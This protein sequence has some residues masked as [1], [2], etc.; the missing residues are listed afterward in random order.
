[1]TPLYELL[2]Q[3][4]ESNNPVTKSSLR[5]C[6]RERVWQSTNDEISVEQFMSLIINLY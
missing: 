2:K 1:M 3:Y 6:I 5:D 4:K